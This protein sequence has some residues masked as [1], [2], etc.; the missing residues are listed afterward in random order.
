MAG[1]PGCKT[2]TPPYFLMITRQPISYEFLADA[3]DFYT[4]AREYKYLEVPW[5]VEKEHINITLPEGSHYRTID[6]GECGL[7]GSGEQGFLSM[8]NQLEKDQ[9]YCCVSPCFRVEPSLSDITYLDF[10]KVEL[11]ALVK[12]EKA[13]KICTRLLED[14]HDFMDRYLLVFSK[15]T[16]EYSYDLF[17]KET[18][19]GSYGFRE[20]GEY[21]WVYGTGLAEPRFS[22]IAT[23]ALAGYH[24][25][26]IPKVNVG[27]LEKI[28]EEYRELRDAANSGNLIMS[29]V[30]LSDMVGAIK[31]YAQNLGVTLEDL[32]I[33]SEATEKA[34]ASGSRSK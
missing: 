10:I 32:I 33:M 7:V 6:G 17:H 2:K 25:T 23:Q 30:E 15:E 13:P 29:L 24:N 9:L 21:S 27:E 11:G 20:L 1:G 28:L 31:L 4:N 19:L 14:A 8:I 34:F 22:Y 26:P 12:I 3:V 16:G 5:I 18:E